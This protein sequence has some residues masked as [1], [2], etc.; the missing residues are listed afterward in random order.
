VIMAWLW[1]VLSVIGVVALT[2]F[3]L[4]I[5]QVIHDASQP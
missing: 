4:F 5:M 2:L 3:A 1:I